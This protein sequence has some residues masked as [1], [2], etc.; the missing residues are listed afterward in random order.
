MF[1]KKK[2]GIIFTEKMVGKFTRSNNEEESSME[3]TLT[4][5]SDDVEQMMKE[6]ADHAAEISGTVTCAELSSEPMTVSEGMSKRTRHHDK[7][8]RV[9]IVS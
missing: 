8:P 9:A 6:D 1:E 5:E 7:L 3:F 2:P 4:I